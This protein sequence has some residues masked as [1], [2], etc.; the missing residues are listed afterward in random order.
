MRSIR[1]LTAIPAAF[2]LT[3]GTV[4]MGLVATTAANT[5]IGATPSIASTAEVSPP[6]NAIVTP[7]DGSIDLD[8]TPS[9]SSGISSYRVSTQ[10]MTETKVIPANQNHAHLGNLTNGVPYLARIVAVRGDS[11]SSVVL[12][13]P[14]VTE[15]VQYRQRRLGDIAPVRARA[16]FEPPSGSAYLGV[17]TL[18]DRIQAFN[19]AAGISTQPAIFN[20]YTA[21][22]G[23]VG[24]A[25]SYSADWPG[26]TPMVSWTVQMSDNA[27]LNGSLDGYFAKQAADVK[28][29]GKAVFLR[30]N[31]EMNGSWYPLYD[32][33]GGTSPAVFVASWQYIHRFFTG[34]NNAAFVWSPNIG[35]ANTAKLAP[36]SWYPG[37]NEVDWIAADAYPDYNH[38]ASTAIFGSNGLE[39]LAN[40]S[41]QRGK[42]FML[43]EWARGESNSTPDTASTIDLVFDWAEAHPDTV[44]ALLYF[45]YAGVRQHD[46]ES[47]PNA[48]AAFR[49]RTVS[50]P[51]YLDTLVGGS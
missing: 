9:V 44:K 25:I 4:Q 39:E 34:V 19:A 51:R 5:P 28:A 10:P 36:F 30:L 43:A 14:I 24:H 8:W 32:S 12:S 29:Y 40:S 26:M 18:P 16:K 20:A 13:T 2:L 17:S 33:A 27:V 31:W 23:S 47:H 42:P 6:T 45:D 35:L 1:A 37:D 46:L 41:A 21:T 3:L 15:D 38:P 7:G 49:A 48:A 22:N 50:N 11:S